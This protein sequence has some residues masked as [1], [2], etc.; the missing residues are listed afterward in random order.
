[1]TGAI[2]CIEKAV[3]LIDGIENFARTTIS[4]HGDRVYIYGE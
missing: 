3:Q 4:S 1:M 2:H